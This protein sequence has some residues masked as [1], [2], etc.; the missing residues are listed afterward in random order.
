MLVAIWLTYVGSASAK[1]L[2]APLR[3]QQQ[4][5]VFIPVAQVRIVLYSRNN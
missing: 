2:L 5:L 3:G 4:Q 1:A